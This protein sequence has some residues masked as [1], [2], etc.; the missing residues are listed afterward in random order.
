MG[1]DFDAVGL[2]GKRTLSDLIQKTV[3]PFFQGTPDLSAIAAKA[4][5]LALVA[6]ADFRTLAARIVSGAGALAGCL[7]DLGYRVLTGGTDN[8]LILV[9]ILHSG[10]TGIIAERALEE[11][12]VI[13]NKNKIP[14]DKKPPSITSGLRLGTN[15]LALR[16]MTAEQM[17][18]CAAL[19]DRV[20]TS[21]EVHGDTAYA[22]D[23]AVRRWVSQEVQRL[24]REY[25]LR[26]YPMIAADRSPPMR[27]SCPARA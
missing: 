22:L 7:S 5:A 19:I 14:G 8:H 21:L 4:R 20:L 15:T 1:R 2:D 12:G 3:F 11:C 23:E 24:C 10:V 27:S 9:D 13:V 17:P 16:G 18:Q 25:P 26:D 6:T